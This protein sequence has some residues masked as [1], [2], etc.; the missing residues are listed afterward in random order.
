MVTKLDP[1][2][3][4]DAIKA[5]ENRGKRLHESLAWQDVW[6][7]AHAQGFTVAKSTGFDILDD[8][9]KAVEKALNE[10]QTPRQFAK[11]LT[12]VLQAKGWWGRKQVIDPAT[13]RP[14]IAQLGSPRRLQTIFDVNM[15]VSYAAG[16]WAAFERT[17]EA[18]PYLRYVAILDED[19]RPAH[20]AR[21]NL[22]LPVDH[23][24][25]DMWAPPC[26]WNCRCTLQ[27][28]SERDVKKLQAE[29]EALFFEP[30]ADVMTTYVNRRT[31]VETQ[32][33]DG[34]DPGWAYNPGKAGYLATH[35]M[36][37]LATAPPELA[38]GVNDDLEWLVKPVAKEF[39]RWFDLATKG[40]RVERSTIAVGALNGDVLE[41]L[42]KKGI[43]P[44]SG[45]ITLD[46]TTAIHM[47]RDA[48]VEAG[49]A[50]PVDSLRRLPELI[51][52]PKAILLDIQENV[53]VYV[54]DE[55]SDPRKG[56]FAINMDY[57]IKVR[58]EG[59]KP[60]KVRANA[61]RTAGLVERRVLTDKN[62]YEILFGEL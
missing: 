10:G 37:K 22:C 61:I 6:Q 3:P 56:K 48:K 29:G 13:G 15:R 50:V 59:G 9:Y 25:W 19:T 57:R 31:G 60:V 44:E 28:L 42:T 58:P 52:R 32:V 14:T 43:Y 24:Y 1:L 35:G 8:I 46:Q 40:G 17:K 36:D 49:K 4:S 26:G 47:I 55:P 51:A 18:R 53:L 54:F 62:K 39:E 38:A 2:K 34:I 41:G 20:R 11:E 16:H 45:A 27:S 33:P 21:H 5:L 12:P 23:P 30:P 7:E